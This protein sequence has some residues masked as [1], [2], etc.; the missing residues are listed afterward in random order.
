[1]SEKANDHAKRGCQRL[2][3]NLLWKVSC[4]ERL[5]EIN[6]KSVM[7][8]ISVQRDLCPLKE[9]ACRNGWKPI[10][11][12]PTL[13]RKARVIVRYVLK[14]HGQRE[15]NRKLPPADSASRNLVEKRTD[16]AQI[17]ISKV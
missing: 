3:V 5:P 16:T 10:F 12:E 4:K 7:E 11:A 6:R 17:K 9:R 8:S 13:L 15:T 1:M 2:I 14:Q